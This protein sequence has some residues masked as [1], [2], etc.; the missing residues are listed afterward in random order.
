VTCRSVN[1]SSS[2][3]ERAHSVPSTGS[4]SSSLAVSNLNAHNGGRLFCP[5]SSRKWA[6]RSTLRVATGGAGADTMVWRKR[7]DADGDAAATLPAR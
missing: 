5:V 3:V 7:T 4:T 6:T 2:L 1:G